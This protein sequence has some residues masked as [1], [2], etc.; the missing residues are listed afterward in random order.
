MPP[1]CNQR[2]PGQ[3]TGVRSFGPKKWGHAK[4]TRDQNDTL[5]IVTVTVTVTEGEGEG[6]AEQKKIL[7]FFSNYYIF[8]SSLLDAVKVLS[9]KFKISIVLLELIAESSLSRSLNEMASKGR[10]DQILTILPPQPLT[11]A[12][13]VGALRQL[14]WEYRFWVGHLRE[15]RDEKFNAVVIHSETL[16]S[17]FVAAHLAP[18]WSDVLVLHPS[19]RFVEKS[20]TERALLARRFRHLYLVTSNLGLAG[21]TRQLIRA[22]S[23]KC[24]RLLTPSAHRRLTGQK[25]KREVIA[26]WWVQ[27]GNFGGYIVEAGAAFEEVRSRGRARTLAIYQF[28]AETKGSAPSERKH[29]LL[30][31]GGDDGGVNSIPV[32]EI[33]ED[34]GVLCRYIGIT[35]VVVRPHPRFLG[36][37]LEF[38]NQLKRLGIDAR[39]SAGNPT[40]K[41][42]V[43]KSTLVFGANNTSSLLDSATW[44]GD[45]PLIGLN[46]VRL[47][48][49]VQSLRGGLEIFWYERGHHSI[50]QIRAELSKQ[51]AFRRVARR[52]TLS[53]FIEGF[54]NASGE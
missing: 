12:G 27:G 25:I 8:E 3:R 22:G 33:C 19:R 6:E 11:E 35:E 50:T 52:G 49:E 18:R 13:K 16:V 38:I 4:C 10:V 15:L 41:N 28:R 5:L 24:Y 23:A 1:C 20:M 47:L 34:V 46:G 44:A 21:A 2:E 43:R 45:R 31:L 32:D 9:E 48:E 36:Q 51:I 39:V 42:Q 37:S 53:S 29:A 26:R 7:I 40:L 17:D 14:F 54:V 30:L